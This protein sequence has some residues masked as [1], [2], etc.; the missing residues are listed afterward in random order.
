MSD[1]SKNTKNQKAKAS[2][3]KAPHTE[4]LEPELE[5]KPKTS[6]F[7]IPDEEED[8]NENEENPP[9]QEINNEKPVKSKFFIEEEEEEKH[10]KEKSEEKMAK[11][12]FFAENDEEEPAEKTKNT[13]KKGKK[14]KKEEKTQ[15]E[16]AQVPEQK[17]EKKS[18]SNF[19]QEEEKNIEEKVEE[20]VEKKV[21][22]K[23]GDKSEEKGGDPTED[24]ADQDKKDKKKEKKK[25]K[26]D[27]QK[28]KKDDKNE[29]KKIDKKP[30]KLTGAAKLAQEKMIKLKEEEDIIRKEE[31]ERKRIE[32]ELLKKEQEEEKIRKEIEDKKKKDKEEKVAQMKKEGTYMTKKQKEKLAIDHMKRKQL[33]EMGFFQQAEKE[34]EEILEKKPEPKKKFIKKKNELQELEEKLRQKE[35]E[36]QT[37]II[38]PNFKA[39][40]QK[41]QEL[42]QVAEDWS[43]LVNENSENLENDSQIPQN[44]NKLEA[45]KVDKKKDKVKKQ[46]KEKEK[47][48]KQEQAKEKEKE[49]E[50]SLEEE[51]LSHLLKNTDQSLTSGQNLMELRSPIC[52]ILGHVDTG[53]TTILDRI[54]NT[55]VQEGEAG[56]ITQQIGATFFPA[57]KLITEIAKLATFY[58]INCSV[59]GLLIIDTPGHESFSNL[60][61]RGSSLCDIAILV[62]DLMHGIEKQT[63]ESL[64]LLK[65]RKTPFIVALNKIDRIY[66]WNTYKN[67]S[68]Y[69][70]LKKQAKASQGEFKKRLDGVITELAE[71]GF[72]A[73]LFWENPD[74]TTYVSLVP[75]SGITGEGLPDLLGVILKYSS[76]FLRQKIKMLGDIFDCTVL[77]VKMIEGLGTTIDVILVNGELKEGDRIV[78]MGFDGP[79]VTTIRALLTPHPMKEMRVKNEYIHHK[80]IEF[81]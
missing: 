3:K 38:D 41:A 71:K 45:P 66:G 55:N 26:K 53:K 73:A 6:K 36:T 5:P 63:L 30:K 31:E 29:E 47:E 32:D 62:I 28:E 67:E 12:K 68:S 19:F 9:K 61:S 8:S 23:D 60:R 18:Q 17:P 25:A 37:K 16:P 70:S 34:S 21:E 77:E 10:K 24:K 13:K 2:K 1:Q 48:K 35:L 52:C 57:N 40:E 11:S 75:T 59:P 72:N 65:M 33:E 80:V 15:N 58:E 39:E 78:L 79:I 27:A 46:E 43:Q 64:E 74:V 51:K 81:Y 4:V 69:I 42:A 14:G 56:G 50:T 22:E 49:K 44:E 20:K 7:F 54:R 76:K